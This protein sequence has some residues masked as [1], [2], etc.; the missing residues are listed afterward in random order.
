[1]HRELLP[2][3]WFQAMLCSP[4]RSGLK[5]LP[6]HEPRKLL[7]TGNWKF[8]EIDVQEARCGDV[9]FA[10]RILEPKLLGH[11]ALLLGAKEIFHV[12]R[13]QGGVVESWESFSATFEQKLTQSQI[14]YID[15]RNKE[16]REKYKGKFIV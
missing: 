10:K 4:L 12:R 15:P 1:M 5:L 13:D 8:H 7:S 14:S 9:L 2:M 11:A 3:N 6:P 16:L